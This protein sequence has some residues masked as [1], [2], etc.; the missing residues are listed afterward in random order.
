MRGDPPAATANYR[1]CS[2]LLG[3]PSSCV[4]PCRQAELTSL[5]EAEQQRSTAA[6]ALA[7]EHAAAAL[8]ALEGQAPAVR[9]RLVHLARVLVLLLDSC[10]MPGDLVPSPGAEVALRCGWLCLGNWA[11]Q[12]PCALLLDH[13]QMVLRDSLLSRQ[14]AI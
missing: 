8:K 11:A 13:P 4:S 9:A 12:P 3:V 5:D 1:I 6:A 7:R 14:H 10:V 2:L